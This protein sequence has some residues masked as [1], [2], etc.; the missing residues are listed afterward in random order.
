VSFGSDRLW[1]IQMCPY[2]TST[3]NCEQRVAWVWVGVP[4]MTVDDR[5]VQRLLSKIWNKSSYPKGITETFWGSDESL[6]VV[7]RYELNLP[8]GNVPRRNAGSEF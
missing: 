3:D 6:F 8:N 5:G 4:T 7:I 2:W 1:R